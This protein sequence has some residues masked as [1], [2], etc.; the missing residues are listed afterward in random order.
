MN[1]S[2]TKGAND[3]MNWASATDLIVGNNGNLNPKVDLTRAEVA[4]VFMKFIGMKSQ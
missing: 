4:M 1:E 2:V 3:A